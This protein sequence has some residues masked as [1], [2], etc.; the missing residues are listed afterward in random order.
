MLGLE[1]IQVEFVIVMLHY[2]YHL[3]AQIL[4]IGTNNRDKYNLFDFNIQFLI[5]G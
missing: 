4:K 1:S 2:C 5:L 3:I